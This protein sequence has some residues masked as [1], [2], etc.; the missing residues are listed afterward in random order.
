MAEPLVQPAPRLQ[1]VNWL[2]RRWWVF[3]VTFGGL[4]I[5]NAIVVALARQGLTPASAAALAGVAY[6][7]IALN[8]F[9]GLIYVVGATA[10]ELVQLAASARIDLAAI[11]IG[12]GR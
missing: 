10:Y 1:E 8:A 7:L 12:G 9:V 6:G 3:G 11:K 4:V 5:L 2:W